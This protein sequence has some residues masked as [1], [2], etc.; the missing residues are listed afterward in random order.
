MG[1]GNAESLIQLREIAHEAGIDWVPRNG[2]EAQNYAILESLGT[3][4]AIADYD[5]DGQLDIFL[6]GGGTFG[7]GREISPLPMALYR[8]RDPWKFLSVQVSAGLAPIRRYSHGT[9]IA[10]VDEDGFSDLL[11][12]GYGGLQLFIN[13]GDG[14]FFDHT[15]ASLL[16]DHA[17]SSAAAWG[18]LNRDGILDLYVGHYVN[19]SFDNHPVCGQGGNGRRIVCA[20]SSFQGLPCIVY[21]G[22][23][24]GTFVESS[25]ELGI[26]QIGKTLGVVMADIDG[27]GQLDI[28]VANDTIPNHLYRRQTSGDFKNVGLENGVALGEKGE[29]DGSMGVDVGDLDGDGRLDIWVANFENESF[30]F[31]RNQGN[32]LF[33]HSSRAFGVTAVGTTAVGFGT[34]IFDVNGDGLQDIFCANGHINAPD[35]PTDRRQL[36]FLFLNERV[37]RLKNIAPTAGEYFRSRHLGRGAACGDLDGNGTPDLVV[38]NLQE[39]VALLKNET[40]IENWVSVRLIGRTSPRSAIGARVTLTTDG[41]KQVKVVRGGGSYLSTSDLAVLFGMGE[42]HDIDTIEIE[43]PSGLKQRIKQVARN[44]NLVIVEPNE[45]LND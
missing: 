37:K 29:S 42:F 4:C 3:G 1:V 13:Q 31:Y 27:K 17:W 41:R 44:H 26:N 28:Y 11:I 16:T 30:A 10:D 35:F 39:P 9:F 43:W 22:N 25:Q 45:T 21:L 36:P 14:T 5:Q 12:T 8:Q 34:I 6:T 38:A 7:S 19:W 33:N 32:E 20:P 40:P 2:E 24:D 18:D 23:G 15:E